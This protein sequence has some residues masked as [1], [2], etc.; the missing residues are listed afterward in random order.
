MSSPAERFPTDPEDPGHD[1]RDS[2][3]GPNPSP[4]PNSEAAPDAGAAAHARRRR[5][6]LQ[7]QAQATLARK[8]ATARKAHRSIAKA[9]AK[10]ARALA[11]LQ[12]WSSDPATAKLLNPDYAA[13]SVRGPVLADADA[14]PRK[15][16]A[17]ED[18]EIARRTI[19]TEVACS[20]RLADRTAENLIGESS[21]FAGPMQATLTAM[22]SGEISYRHGQVLMEQLSF[23]PLEEAA[24]FEARLLPVA[25]DLTV[26]KLAVKARRM[27]ERAHPETLTHRATAAVAERGVW[28]EGRADGMG[29][30]T[31]YGTAVQTQAALDML[32]SI[33]ETTQALER[34]DASIPEMD[35]RTIGQI[36]ADAMADLVLDGVTPAGTGG[37]IR[38][39]VMVTVPVFTLMGRTM[40]PGFLE[41]YGPIPADTAREIAA[42]CPSFIRILT[43]PETG[44]VLSVGKEHYTAPADMRRWVALRD[45]TCRFP[46]CTRPASRSDIDHTIAR[47]HGGPTDYD[48]LAHLCR[49]HHRLK[50][51]TLWAVVQEPGG[52]LRWT[53]PAG[54]THRTYPETTLGPPPTLAPT[55]EPPAT[56][57]RPRTS[58]LPDDPP[59]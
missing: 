34:H 58:D 11:D 53:S 45:G 22:S 46:G 54:E 49:A 50:H 2:A 3:G 17:W 39:S 18:Q 1:A 10:R 36:C 23:L 29:T 12:R 20:L 27:R 43:H 42:G 28:W 41:G 32:T 5:R 33:V 37:G 52:V 26:G 38:G 44:A 24:E 4:N 21:L 15:I 14:S 57:A 51:Q 31:W 8:V 6:T 35:R 47:E 9:T 48:N 30:L 25:K 56:S 19:T 59:F 7:E 55:P 40:E 16:P 13:E